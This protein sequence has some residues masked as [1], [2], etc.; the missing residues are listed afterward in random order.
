MPITV[1]RALLATAGATVFAWHPVPALAQQDRNIQADCARIEDPTARLACYDSK[2]RDAGETPAAPVPPSSAPSQR[3]SAPVASV[4]AP[5]ARRKSAPSPQPSITSPAQLGRR[6][7]NVTAVTEK[8]PGAYLITL[9]DGAQWGFAEDMA[10]TYRA[11]QGGSTVQIERGV[12]GN[13]R[14][15]FDGQQPVRVRRIR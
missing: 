2:N 10:P 13:Y 3:G 6:T 11:P 8:G 15:R 4:A 5:E 14:M 7:V 9:A 1:H 12:L